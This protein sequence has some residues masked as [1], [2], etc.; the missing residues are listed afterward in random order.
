[1]N[2]CLKALDV[3]ERGKIPPRRDER[4]L[5]SVLG[6][7]DVTQD[8]MRDGEQPVSRAA[9]DGGKRLLVPGPRCFDERQVHRSGSLFAPLGR[10]ASPTM[11]TSPGD[12]V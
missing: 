1:M 12:R 9:G 5:D 6:A 10:D 7:S 4:L 2:P 11:S 3:A 8:P